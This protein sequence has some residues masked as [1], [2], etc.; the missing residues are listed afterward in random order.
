MV[1]LATA[2][3]AKFPEAVIDAGVPKPAL[4][5]FLKDLMKLKEKFSV[6]KNNLEEVKQFIA[7]RAWNFTP[8]TSSKKQLLPSWPL[9]AYWF[10][11]SGLVARLAS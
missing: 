11:W 6:L 4:P 5:D 8:V 1:S 9:L 7:E 2:H 10:Y 3:P